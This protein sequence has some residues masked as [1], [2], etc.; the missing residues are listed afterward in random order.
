M[1]TSLH[2]VRRLVVAFLLISALLPFVEAKSID[3]I[4]SHTVAVNGTTLHYLLAGKGR[5]TPVVLLHGYTQTS[6]MWRPLMAQLAERRV[7]I[8]PD[9]RG[10]GLS[11][12]P[13]GGYDKKTMAQDVH[14]LVQSLGYPSVKIVGH[15]V[16]LMV[17]YAYAAQYQDDVES[18]VLMDSFL[19]GIG[20]WRKT[21]LLHEQWHSHF[22]VSMPLQL[23]EGRERIYFDH[24]WNDFAADPERSLSEQD[25]QLYTLAYA[26]PGGMRAGL[27]YFRAFEQDAL[28][29]AEFARTKLSVPMLVLAGE[30]ASGDALLRQ[31]RLVAISVR[32]IVIRGS[33]HWIMEEAPQQTVRAL[34]DFINLPKR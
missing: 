30:K 25:R 10:A 24:F 22:H 29:F 17:A 20:D 2:G 4:E 33:G 15:G 31:G 28:D 8:A 3:P 12:R 34:T 16:G 9:L 19:P 23:V 7:V 14:A 5:E 26:Q 32:G 13:M 1:I 6:H 21:R 18:V 27:E 11:A